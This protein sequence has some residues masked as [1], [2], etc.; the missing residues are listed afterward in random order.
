VAE[1]LNDYGIRP[2]ADYQ[3]VL[4]QSWPSPDVARRLHDRPN[5]I[6][7]RVRLELER[8]DDAEWLEARATRWWQR[9]VCVNVEDRRLR[10]PYV[11]VDAA[12]VSRR[13]GRGATSNALTESP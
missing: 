13:Y 6:D 2:N 10:V 12:D 4:N 1:H 3:H 7:V 11:W 9:H 5:A 8:G